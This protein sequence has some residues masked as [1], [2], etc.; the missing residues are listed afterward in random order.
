MK[1]SK[2]LHG[3]AILLYGPG[4]L[5]RLADRLRVSPRTVKR[6]THGELTIPPGVWAE[7]LSDPR[8]ASVRWRLE[9][10]A[11]EASQSGSSRRPESR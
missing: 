3:V 11:A 4:W 10:L 6:W 7:L 9:R 5:D 2:L 8:L 1:P